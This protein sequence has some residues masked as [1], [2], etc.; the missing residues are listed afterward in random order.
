[1]GGVAR[2]PPAR[3]RGSCWPARSSSKPP[4]PAARPGAPSPATTHMNRECQ[5]ENPIAYPTEQAPA[6]TLDDDSARSCFTSPASVSDAMK[7]VYL[8]V[9][10][11]LA[12]CA[13]APAMLVGT[14]AIGQQ[15]EKRLWETVVGGCEESDEDKKETI[16]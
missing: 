15:K 1:M 6:E 13:T 5:T 4:P 12:A 8:P 16:L 11:H 2:L 7:T 14:D 9:S 3:R 10:R